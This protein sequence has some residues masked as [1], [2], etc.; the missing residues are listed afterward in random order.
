[1]GVLPQGRPAAPRRGAFG[2]SKMTGGR[3]PVSKAA[4]S[5]AWPPPQRS[6]PHPC[7]R[8]FCV[9]RSPRASGP[10]STGLWMVRGRR[11]AA[12][13]PRGGPTNARWLQGDRDRRGVRLEKR[14]RYGRGRWGW[15]MPRFSQ[16]PWSPCSSSSRSSRS[17]S[18]V[19]SGGIY[20]PRGVLLATPAASP[21]S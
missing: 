1:M 15:R 5:Q 6:R 18:I 10:T 16:S 13:C 21:H 4:A 12:R 3:S 17:G 14:H 19:V 20:A 2:L 7:R 9:I 11:S 8:A